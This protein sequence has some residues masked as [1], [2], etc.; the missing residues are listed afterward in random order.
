MKKD[1]ITRRDFLKIAG[2]TSAGLALS[3][4]GVKAA[5][6]PTSTTL[7]TGTSIAEASL[8][9]IPTITP[10]P[11]TLASLKDLSVWVDDY[12]HAYGDK[13]KIDDVEMNAK[14]L[15]DEIRNKPDTYIKNKTVNGI[16]HPFLV[17]NEAPLAFAGS[18]KKWN[19]A[20]LQRLAKLKGIEFE[21]EWAGNDFLK[22]NNLDAGK[23]KILSK[24]IGDSFMV[25]GGLQTQ[26]VF[27]N[28]TT[29]TWSSVVDNWESVKNQ[30]DDKNVP[31][32]YP[33]Y[34]D[35]GK[36]MIHEVTEVSISGHPKIRGLWLFH[37]GE[38]SDSIRNGDFSGEE[39]SHILEFIIK[40]I[41][42]QFPEV[43]RWD[44]TD[45]LINRFLAFTKP[46][47]PQVRLW[48][49][50]LDKSPAQVKIPDIADLVILI[51]QWIKEA[52]ERAEIIITEDFLLDNN[53]QYALTSI[54]A[55]NELLEN[56]S[57]KSKSFLFYGI[58][59]E[60]NILVYDGLDTEKMRA[61]IQ[62]W[63][64]W[65]FQLF[66]SETMIICSAEYRAWLKG[67]LMG[68]VDPGEQQELMY[69]Q[70]LQLYLDAGAPAFGF[71][72]LGDMDNW[73][74]MGSNPIHNTAPGIFDA[75][76][77]KKRPYFAL[78]KTLF[79]NI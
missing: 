45:E 14:Q 56:I 1:K 72:E 19:E 37:G 46:T 39:L 49:K 70:L 48:Y 35:Y 25:G 52:N 76:Y 68:K 40:S 64:G 57:S 4:C 24:L 36:E 63:K 29:Q 26:Q 33:Y 2:V 12:T 67:R 78:A 50:I 6:L 61:T 75:D 32:G 34:F 16:D 73:I 10:M 71:G 42:L 11:E 22:Q 23:Y 30:L 60:N 65:G 20:S 9:P 13:I 17:V 62:K 51:A 3:A 15:T 54:N 7:P 28:F 27:Q 59:C 43:T 69:A 31:P 8:T 21:F 74:E 53:Y 58:D 44:A 38:M 5:E 66:S 41:V 77:R 18:D 55:F 47:D 79:E